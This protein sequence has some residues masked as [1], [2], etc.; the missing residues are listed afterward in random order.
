M[1]VEDVAQANRDAEAKL[2][3]KN[4]MG[5]LFGFDGDSD[6]W[7]A[8]FSGFPGLESAHR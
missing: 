1:L 3:G 5:T 6:A 7:V 8:L 4:P 2:R